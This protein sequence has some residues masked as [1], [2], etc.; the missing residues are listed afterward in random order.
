MP[1]PTHPCI[2][3]FLKPIFI[4]YMASLVTKA[5]S[6]CNYPPT[7]ILHHAQCLGQ[8]IHIGPQV[9]QL[10]G[11]SLVSTAMTTISALNK[12]PKSLLQ[13]WRFVSMNVYM[14]TGGLYILHH[15]MHH[16]RMTLHESSLQAYCDKLQ[17]WQQSL[18]HPRADRTPDTHEQTQIG[19]CSHSS[20]V[21]PIT[22][23]TTL[24]KKR[25]WN[26]HCYPMP[27]QYVP[28][29]SQEKAAMQEK[30]RMGMKHTGY[31]A[32]LSDTSPEVPQMHQESAP[33]SLPPWKRLKVC[34]NY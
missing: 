23:N 7:V 3:S 24:L 12:C 5:T 30:A 25:L 9:R 11:P 34:I 6:W 15:H 20:Y 4:I 33:G 17:A 26:T 18:L 16:H 32:E 13:S 31:T 21:Q 19:P 28:W 27:V 29:T 22:N 10:Q 1:M 2:P 8:C 14:G